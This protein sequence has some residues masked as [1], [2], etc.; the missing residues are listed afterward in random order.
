MNSRSDV[1]E[2]FRKLGYRTSF[3]NWEEE[4]IIIPTGKKHGISKEAEAKGEFGLWDGMLFL[5]KSELGGWALNIDGH[6]M[7]SDKIYPTLQEA[8][9]AAEKI[10]RERNT[11][12]D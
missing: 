2:Y 5:Y 1:A 6:N 11:D 7:N 10:V 12:L 3:R 4:G 8:V 9:Y